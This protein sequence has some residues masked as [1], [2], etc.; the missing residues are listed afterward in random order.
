MRHFARHQSHGGIPHFPLNP[1]GS[2]AACP[3]AHRSQRT[4]PASRSRITALTLSPTANLLVSGCV[5]SWARIW[6]AR[7]AAGSSGAGGGGGG[8]GGRCAPVASLAT[9]QGG[10][11]SLLLDS[12]RL[13]LY[14]GGRDGTAAEW[15][16]RK[17]RQV[18][19]SA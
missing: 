18:D 2:A 8:G 1:R 14:T 17:V 16:L 11:C 19:V 7:L 5:A 15:D 9:R 4:V 13:R 6:D 10:V 3:G 12:G